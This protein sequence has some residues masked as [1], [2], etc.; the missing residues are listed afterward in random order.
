MIRRIA[1]SIV[2]TAGATASAAN[3]AI[4]Y[5]RDIRPI[6]AEACFKCHGP[7]SASRQ[8]DLRLDQRDAAMGMT[9]I[10][11]GKPGESEL[12]RRIFSTDA[13]EAMPPK[14]QQRQLTVSEKE[15]L[16]SWIASGAEYQPHWSFIAPKRPMPPTVKT[17]A[18]VR[19]PIDNFVLARLESMGLSPAPEADRRT[20]VRRLSLDLTGLPPSPEL[21]EEFVN[22][23]S[24]DAYGKLVDQRFWNLGRLIGG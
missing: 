23:P 17:A 12:I 6:L 22:D 14:E 4:E 3:P 1:L 18:W 8:A 11:P 19:N 10:V 9:A 2:L 15:L 7:D 13:M 21:V 20:L 24:D 5:N 16:K